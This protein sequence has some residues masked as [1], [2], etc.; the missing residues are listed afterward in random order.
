MHEKNTIESVLKKSIALLAACLFTAGSL[1]CS[2]K[3]PHNTADS[4]LQPITSRVTVHDPSIVYDSTTQ[5]YYVYGSHRAW[6]SSVDLI[7]WEYVKNNINRDFAA[8]F[9]S[10]GEWSSRG[11]DRYDISG[12][13]W[14]P[15]V[16]YNESMKKWCMYMS[17]NGDNY[18]SSIAMATADSIDGPYTYAGTVVYSGFTTPEEAAITDYTKVTGDTE[19]ASRY[20]N[21]ARKWNSSYGTNAIDPC[22]FYDRD[23]GLWMSYGSWFGGIHLLKLDNTT[24]LR[25]YTYTYETV[26]NASD[27]YLGIRLSGGYG[28]TGEGSYIVWDEESGYYYLYLSYCG[29]NATDSFSGYH[30]RL[31]RSENVTGPYVDAA[32]GTGIC[33]KPGTIQKDKGIRLFGNYYF[34]SLADAVKGS[35]AEK[36]YMSGGHNSAI[37]TESGERFLVYHTR[38]NLGTEWHQ[39]R[40]HQQFL[41]EDNWP[42][43]A[44]Y[45]YLGSEISPT[46]YAVSDI[47]G[48]YEYINHGLISATRYTGM[49]E[50]LNVT[51]NEDGTITGDVT[52]TWK[53]T[54]GADGKNYYATMTINDVVYKGVFFKQY[55]ESEAHN[56]VMTFSLIGSDN[57]S[58]W[59]SKS[60]K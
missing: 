49:L 24:G 53:E 16:I 2:D 7:N 59:G 11:S 12:N 10:N 9:A 50:T 38:F 51:L 1:G 33:T 8:I 26:T 48:N 43:T 25:D 14:A 60:D 23:G 36:G 30:I 35:N 52:G 32:G 57:Q 46:G 55:D 17:I 29:L 22:V 54:K 19:V 31:F 34:S 40:V 4:R 6:A 13:C 21:G 47:A 20:L 28:C 3:G 42:V 37:I 18:Y 41:N 44:V 39:I 56:E 45:E 5:T 58:I 15:D 27:A